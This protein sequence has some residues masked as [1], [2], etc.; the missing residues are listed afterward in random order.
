MAIHSSDAHTTNEREGQ[1]NS[2][3][4]DTGRITSGPMSCPDIQSA[5]ILT[6]CFVPYNG[7]AFPPKGHTYFYNPSR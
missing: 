2:L 3:A 5:F 7:V 1:K 4:E 6:K